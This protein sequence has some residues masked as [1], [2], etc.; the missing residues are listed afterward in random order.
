MTNTNA[1]QEDRVP[2]DP[3]KEDA[4]A[5]SL[6]LSGLPE[7]NDNLPAVVQD[8]DTNQIKQFITQIRSAEHQVGEHIIAALQDPDTVAVLT[9]VVIGPKGGQHIVSAG[10]DPET[11][12]EVQKMLVK[13]EEDRHEDIPCV[14]FHCFLKRKPKKEADGD[15]QA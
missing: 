14:G 8:V 6:P 2:I 7:G 12:E 4:D 5:A 13:A 11:L 1:D 10:L 9:T 15:S 3:D